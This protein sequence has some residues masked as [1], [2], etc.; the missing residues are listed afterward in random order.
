MKKISLFKTAL[1]YLKQHRKGIAVFLAFALIYMSVFSL[2]KLPFEAVAY[3]S[4]L[5]VFLGFIFIVIDFIFYYISHKKLVLIQNEIIYKIEELPLPKNQIEK[6]YTILLEILFDEIKRINL[7]AD[8]SK[9]ETIQYYTL[10]VHQI[11]TPIAAMNLILQQAD[12]EQNK[13]ILAELFKIEQYVELVLSYLRLNSDSN[14][15]LIKEYP[16]D[17]LVKQSVRK[18]APLFIRKKIQL[19]LKPIGINVITDEKWLVFVIEQILSNSLKY[20]NQ[21]SIS[22]YTESPKTLVIKDTGI[23][24]AEEDLPRIGEKGF[25]GYNGREDKKASGLGLYLCKTVIKKLSHSI[26]I[27]SQV[28]KGTT[29]KIDLSSKNITHE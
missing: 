13:I 11:K 20:T 28:G 14:D 4:L 16:L 27:Y 2:Y 3:G 5:C 17:S 9:R 1:E 7:N 25:T 21:G 22:I 6:D 12:T 19:N 23:G 24:I 8:I 15:L 29:V 10:W 18:Y 26:K